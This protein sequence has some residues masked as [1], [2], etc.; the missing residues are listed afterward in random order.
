MIRNLQFAYASGFNGMQAPQP[1]ADMR[2][3]APG[4]D[5]AR[6]DP[7]QETPAQDLAMATILNAIGGH[8]VAMLFKVGRHVI[9]NV[10][11]MGT[12][13][14]RPNMP[15][16]SVTPDP[17]KAADPRA[18]WDLNFR[19]AADAMSRKLK[20]VQSEDSAPSFGWGR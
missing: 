3:P 16:A 12:Q 13:Y 1:L 10:D 14:G 6:K 2:G 5:R 9:P 4:Q 7:E 17:K 8:G 20:T 15:T 19:G 11:E 18:A